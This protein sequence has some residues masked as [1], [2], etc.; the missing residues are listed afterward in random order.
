MA[1]V[2]GG[3]NFLWQFNM[4]AISCESAVR[5]GVNWVALAS[6]AG[7][8]CSLCYLALAPGSGHARHFY[9]VPVGPE[10]SRAELSRTNGVYSS[11]VVGQ[12]P[13][14]VFP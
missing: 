9:A 13:C 6:K 3:A 7:S 5:A 14:V 2:A 8:I 12:H 4:K 10:L 11:P 1:G